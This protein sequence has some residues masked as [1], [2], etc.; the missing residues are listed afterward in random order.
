MLYILAVNMN[1]MEDG[2]INKS[3]HSKVQQKP[4]HGTCCFMIFNYIVIKKIG[5]NYKPVGYK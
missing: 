2:H 4:L 1:K 3:Q 5:K